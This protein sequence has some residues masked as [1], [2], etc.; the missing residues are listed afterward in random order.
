M[1]NLTSTSDQILGCAQSLIENG[2]YNGFSYADIAAAVGIRKASIHYHFP[3]KV[4]LVRTLVEGYRK[5]AE[6]SVEAFANSG[7]GPL[8]QLKSY[9]DYWAQCIKDASRPYCVCALLASEQPVLPA[10]VAA[11]VRQYFSVLSGWLREVL[12]QGKQSGVLRLTS[13]PAVEAEVFMATIHGA[14]LSAR[15]YGD[16]EVFKLITGSVFQRL[17]AQT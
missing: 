10:E 11:E 4:D 15:A 1:S 14:M 6:A 8:E 9:A 12:A 3:M 17:S 2:G 5:H 13:S 7:L 16:P